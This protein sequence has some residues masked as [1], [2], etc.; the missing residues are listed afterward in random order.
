MSSY[1]AQ[2]LGVGKKE[3]VTD[4]YHA[5]NILAVLCFCCEIMDIH[6]KASC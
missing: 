1:T 5:T 2:N 4:G 6:M 3:R